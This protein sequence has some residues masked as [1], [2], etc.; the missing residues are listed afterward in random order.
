MLTPR[1]TAIRAAACLLTGAAIGILL[2]R[3]AAGSAAHPTQAATL[4]VGQQ[5]F[6]ADC[7]IC[8]GPAGDGAGGAPRLDTGLESF[9]SEAALAA[10]I[11]RNMPATAPGSLSTNQAHAI[12]TY[13]WLL[14]HSSR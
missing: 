1:R 12:A 4:V 5:L 6:A 7:A 2:A 8:H 9:P 11:H 13:L 10:F 14:N 3:T